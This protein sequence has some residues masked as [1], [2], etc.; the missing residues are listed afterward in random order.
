VG[1]S[2]WLKF[3]SSFRILSVVILS[4]AF[5]TSVAFTASPEYHATE[6]THYSAQAETDTT[7]SRSPSP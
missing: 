2:D 1:Y 3:F 6:A 7:E 4:S 5:L